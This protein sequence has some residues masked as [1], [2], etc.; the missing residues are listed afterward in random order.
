MDKFEISVKRFDEFASEYAVRFMN[1][2]SYQKHFD[3]FTDMIENSQPKINVF[4]LF[5]FSV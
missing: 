2:E 4:I 1:I 5:A 3:E